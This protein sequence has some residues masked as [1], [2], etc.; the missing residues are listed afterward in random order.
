RQLFLHL[1]FPQSRTPAITTA[2][3][4]K[5]QQTRCIGKIVLPKSLPPASAHLDCELGCVR[6][7]TEVEVAAIVVQVIDAVRNCFANSLRFKIVVVD[8]FGGLAPT[9]SSVLKVANQLFFL[10]IYADH[11]PAAAQKKLLLGMNVFKLRIPIRMLGSRQPF[12]DQSFHA[13]WLLSV[14]LFF[15]PRSSTAH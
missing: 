5:S 8:C 4:A 11:G 10:G 13:M 15:Y 7:L 3:I 14:R 6:G 2:A 1:E 12:R 9:P